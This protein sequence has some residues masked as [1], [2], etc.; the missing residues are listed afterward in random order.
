MFNHL[1]L[2]GKKHKYVIDGHDSNPKSSLVDTDDE[3]TNCCFSPRRKN[4]DEVSPSPSY[5]SIGTSNNREHVSSIED[6]AQSTVSKQ[7]YES[8]KEDLE[9]C[10]KELKECRS[11]KEALLS[12]LSRLMGSKMVENNPQIAN[13]NDANRPQKLADTLGYIYDNEWTD[14]YT[15]LLDVENISDRNSIEILLD[16]LQVAYHGCLNHVDKFTE[17]VQGWFKGEKE[18]LSNR[19]LELAIST[20]TTMIPC[21]QVE[22][23][24]VISQKYEEKIRKVCDPY[25]QRC[26]T[27]CFYM[28]VKSPQVYLEFDCPADKIDRFIFRPFTKDGKTLDYVVWP[29]LFLHKDGPLMT[30][31]VVQCL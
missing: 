11:E 17:H 10:R 20:A 6:R 16:I 18:N 15:H 23:M 1:F 30:K 22:I 21:I 8:L 13:L 9:R 29:A 25:I 14:A 31:G 3:Q 26:T 4:I 27:V 7:Q 28:V 24:Q 2:M 12:R 19:I 5:N